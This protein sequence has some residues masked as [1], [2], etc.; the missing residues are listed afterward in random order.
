MKLPSRGFYNIWEVS[1][2]W[3][4]TP[5]D[6]VEWAMMGHMKLVASLPKI[7]SEGIVYGGLVDL[8]P[9]DLLPYFPRHAN[10]FARIPVIRIKMEGEDDWKLID[11]DFQIEIGTTDVMISSADARNFE[12]QNG[13]APER[14]AGVL[15]KHDWDGMWGFVICRIHEQGI[16]NTQS[17]L[18]RECEE[19]FTRRDARAVPDLSTIL[20]KIR[21]VYR[22]LAEEN[23]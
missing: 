21:P 5:T 17:E 11:E 4:C 9:T 15:N 23:A 16:P 2:R 13:L 22:A 7:V 8:K 10:T 6:V 12:E 19:W 20:K 1:A 18:A 3:G 14:H